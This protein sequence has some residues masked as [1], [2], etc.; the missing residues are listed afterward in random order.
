MTTGHRLHDLLMA[1]SWLATAAI[2]AITAVFALGLRDFEFENS[3]TTWFVD[4]DP[5]LV[6]YENF[7]DRFGSDEA[8]L[9]A[10]DT[11]GDP[12]SNE[13][14]Q[15]VHALS[16]TLSEQPG[17]VDVFSL[18]HLE[19][20]VDDGD[21]LTV[22]PLIEELPPTAERVSQVRGLLDKSPIYQML[23]S[24]DH[25]IT[26]VLL[27]L[28]PTTGGFSPKAKLVRDARV[29]AA[30]HDGGREIWF[31]GGPVIDE[32]LYRNSETDTKRFAPIMA[33]LLIA[34]LGWLFRSAIAVVLPL[35]VVGV[36]IVWAVGFM[37]WMGWSASVLTTVLPPV[38]MAVGVADSIHLLQHFRLHVLRGL[39]PSEALREA[40][41]RVLR[42]C[43]LTTITT[44]AGMASLSAASLSGIRELGLTCAVGV[45][46][47]FL[48]TMVA[49]PLGLRAMP[50]RWLGGLAR[51]APPAMSKALVN[52]TRLAIEWRGLVVTAGIGL[53]VVAGIGMTKVDVGSSMVTYFYESDPTYEELLV[54]D[55]A[56]GG[57]FPFQVLVEATGDGDLLEPEA[58]AGIA[59]IQARLAE[60]PAT[61]R[62]VS[63]L[64]YLSEARRVLRRDPPGDLGIPESREEAAQILLVSEGDGDIERFL[65]MDYRAA[66]IE[67][68]VMASRYE[69][70][71]ERM[72]ASE[73]ELDDA[74][75][76]LVHAEITGL[77]KLMGD[78]EVY[79]VDSQI[80][81]FGT[82]FVLVLG[83]IGLLFR[84]ASAGLL[85]AVPNL[86]PLAMILGLM[87]WVGISLDLTT[88]MVA[89][90]LLGLVVDDTVH[91]LERVLCARDEGATVP[92]AFLI[93]VEEVGYAVVLTSIVLASGFITL[94][95]GSFRPNFNFAVLS[96]TAI[97]LALFA[98]VLLFP[99]VACMVPWLVPKGSRSSG[100]S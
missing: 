42:P 56:L 12:L 88:V 85:S 47:A 93:S 1:H 81:T 44:A 97:W 68:P 31:G 61:G 40:F 10:I 79:L 72:Q 23:V 91:V 65:T 75:G 84:S 13:T 94:V 21:V 50:D 35:F 74:G 20:L 70:L 100:E 24:D 60:Q 25:T 76:A 52:A 33:L 57:S 18:T 29:L 46:A 41:A 98:D 82:A 64:D 3:Y 17:V 22:R 67:V 71:S 99:A 15:I 38:L 32:A 36:S 77:S 14:L 45:V 80:R 95:A 86:F 73:S 69:E 11:A 66:R 34:S 26:A 63:A 59:R 48:L 16:E 62:P 37:S 53:L 78:M 6:A 55:H 39:T 27:T 28:E 87:G 49:L 30:E 90:M 43:V 54:M 51:P 92:E 58:L 5:A 96:V 9:V 2:V 8:I 4:D 7:L 83:C 19:V 89:P